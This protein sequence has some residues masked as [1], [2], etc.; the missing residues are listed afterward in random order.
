MSPGADDGWRWPSAAYMTISSMGQLGRSWLS[1]VVTGLDIPALL[2]QDPT[3]VKVL[4]ERV[5]AS[6]KLWCI[7][8][9]AVRCLAHKVPASLAQCKP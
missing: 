6:G 9:R 3:V 2:S 5:K 1:R 8:S 7:P 4:H